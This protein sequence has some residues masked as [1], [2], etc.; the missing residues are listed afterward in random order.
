MSG[1]ASGQSVSTRRSRREP[2]ADDGSMPPAPTSQPEAL[3]PGQIVRVVV[4]HELLDVL[5][6]HVE[7]HVVPP[8]LR[9]PCKA[10]GLG[11]LLWP[12]ERRALERRGAVEE[13]L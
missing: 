3:L 7:R 11:P 2:S 5:R 9:G 6:R 8:D 1:R 12:P 10:L 13:R 4:V